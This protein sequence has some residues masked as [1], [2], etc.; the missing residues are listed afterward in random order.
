MKEFLK[1]VQEI[2]PKAGLYY[3]GLKAQNREEIAFSPLFSISKYHDEYEF[4]KAGYTLCVSKDASK[5][6][7]VIKAIKECEE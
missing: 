4:R 3:N 2:F 6:I 5:I 1:Q 7:A